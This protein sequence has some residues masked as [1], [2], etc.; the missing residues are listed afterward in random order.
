MDITI[1]LPDELGQQAKADSNVNL[2]RMLR[3]ALVTYYQEVDTVD[4]TL[5]NATEYTLKLED[6][7]GRSYKGRI[8]ATRIA[9]S[10]LLEVFLTDEENVVLYDADKAEYWVIEDPE[11][12]LKD[13]L[14]QD[15][16]LDVMA[17]LGRDPVVDLNI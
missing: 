4:A 3:D 13:S 7:E 6:E 9:D 2:S 16:Y 1:Y 14:D 12:E 8:T 15:A 10:G 5:T 17:A 11:E